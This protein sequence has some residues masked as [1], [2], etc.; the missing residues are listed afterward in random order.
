MKKA[1]P[2]P[3]M[4]IT[5]IILVLALN[6]FHSS[7]GGYMTAINALIALCVTGYTARA[8]LAHFSRNQNIIHWS[9]NPDW[10]SDGIFVSD[11]NGKIQGDNAACRQILSQENTAITVSALLEPLHTLL[12]EREQA[13]EIVSAVLSSPEIKFSDTLNLTDGRVIE[14]VTRPIE[15]TDRRMWVLRDVTHILRAKD[16]HEMHQTML[17]A[18]AART[19]EL[20]EQLYHAKSALEAKQTELTRLA[21]TDS[22]TGLLNRRRLT[23]L[24]QEAIANAAKTPDSEIWVIM[25]DIDHFKRINDTYGHAAGDVAIRDFA[26]IASHNTGKDGFVGRMGGEEFAIILPN[27]SLDKAFKIAENIRKETAAHQ[28]VSDSEKFRYTASFGVAC[29]QKDQISIETA[30]DQ[31]DQALYS[32]KSYGRNRVV[33]YEK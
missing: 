31:A 1:L 6:I 33:G 2:L 21:N 7:F 22:L 8:L 25:M 16:D 26:N 29:W 11:L 5:A 15:G 24:G 14:R 27:G 3:T 4:L 18:D 19:A 20:A 9:I 32:A 30:L 28:T 23:A 17:E 13:D 12:T 10:L